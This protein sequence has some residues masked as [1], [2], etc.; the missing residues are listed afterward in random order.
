M[1]SRPKP[2]CRVCQARSG[3]LSRLWVLL[4]C[5]TSLPPALA[6]P[7][8]HAASFSSNEIKAAFLY[9]FASY[10]EWPQAAPAATFVIGIAGAD[11]IADELERL[12]PSVR[13]DERPVEVRRV[14]T[15]ADLDGVQI[16]YIGAGSRMPGPL[17]DAALTAPR[18]IL[19][20]TD[21]S[22]A[23]PSGAVINLVELDRK[24]RFE[25]SLVEAE[26]RGLKLNSGL[27]S[28][29]IRIDGRPRANGTCIEQ[30]RGNC[31]ITRYAHAQWRGRF[32]KA[33]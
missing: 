22:Q 14:A 17:R 16:L 25:V 7:A 27:L 23:M 28:V 9:R 15:A 26:R 29:A 18:P 33:T 20:V 13:I 32:G 8:A 5:A 11:G 2:E 3:L 24:V 30:Q 1:L 19:V 21:Q 6:A 4:L 10:V 12:V 31:S